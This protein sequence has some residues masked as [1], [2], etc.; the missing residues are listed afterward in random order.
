MT[1]KSHENHIQLQM[2]LLGTA[3]YQSQA[4]YAVLFGTCQLAVSICPTHSSFWLFGA[5][6]HISMAKT[7]AAQMLRTEM[8]SSWAIHRTAIPPLVVVCVSIRPHSLS[9]P[10]NRLHSTTA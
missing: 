7:G 5:Y 8:H 4:Y 10:V 9:Y 6:V 3:Y 1:W 2:S